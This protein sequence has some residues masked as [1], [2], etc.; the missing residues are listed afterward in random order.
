MTSILRNR[1]TVV[2]ALAAMSVVA[3]PG[4]AT[5]QTDAWPARPLRLVTASAAGGGADI[6]ARLVAEGVSRALKQPVIVDNKSGANGMIANDTVAKSR[7]DGYT[8]LF[9]YASAM[10]INATLQPHV[11]YDALKDLAPVAQIGSGG[12]YLV[13]SPDLPV[14]NLKEFVEYARAKG[15]DLEYASWGIGSGGHL[16]M[17]S[18]KQQSGLRIRHVPYRTVTQILTDLQGGTIKVAF[19]DVTSSAPLI[20]SGKLRALAVSGTRRTP[21]LPDIPTMTEQGYRFDADSWYGVFVPTGTP[22]QIVQRLNAE[23]NKVLVSPELAQRFAAANMSAP[24]IKSPAQ[25]AETVRADYRT[26]GEIIRT[27]GVKAE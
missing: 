2:L 11:P 24:P 10:V 19:V 23:I 9:T 20:R 18:L 15:E 14:R 22:P 4:A 13:V 12:S 21:A 27:A 17:E 8:V 25:F 3:A 26:W 1:R 7:P 16:T 6:F 5:A